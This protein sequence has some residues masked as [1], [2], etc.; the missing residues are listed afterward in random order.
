MDCTRVILSPCIAL[1]FGQCRLKLLKLYEYSDC[2]AWLHVVS[3][4]GDDS[5]AA[6]MPAAMAKR[7]F[8]A[9]WYD[10]VYYQ[11]VSTTSVYK[12]NINAL[13]AITRCFG[14]EP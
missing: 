5:A 10:S 7:F 14:T 6:C 2:I 3:A 13:A 11:H 4:A 1:R 12:F 8:V 9:V